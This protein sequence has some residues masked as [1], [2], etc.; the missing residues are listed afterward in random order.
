[1]VFSKGGRRFAGKVGELWAMH[2]RNP[3]FLGS[4]HYFIGAPKSDY[5]W[6]EK[7]ALSDAFR[8]NARFLFEVVPRLAKAGAPI[9][10]LDPATVMD[11]WQRGS[12]LPFRVVVVT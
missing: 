6:D 7:L 11:R 12:L 9:W 5:E 2:G 8:D 4:F 1:M 10:P 3:S